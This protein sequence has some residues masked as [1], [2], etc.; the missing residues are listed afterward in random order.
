VWFEEELL[1]GNIV[2]M[3]FEAEGWNCVADS[4]GSANEDVMGECEWKVEEGECVGFGWTGPRVLSRALRAGSGLRS[5]PGSMGVELTGNAIVSRVC[6]CLID[7]LDCMQCT[8]YRKTSEVSRVLQLRWDQKEDYHEPAS[9]CLLTCSSAC[10]APP[11]LPSGAAFG[12]VV[13]AFAIVDVGGVRVGYLRAELVA[14][15]GSF[16]AAFE[17]LDAEEPITIDLLQGAAS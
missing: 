17:A 10:D 3:G 16:E 9:S 11:R 4:V 1:L 14:A 7:R 8:L 13:C 2:C 12:L 6:V 15:E 5:E